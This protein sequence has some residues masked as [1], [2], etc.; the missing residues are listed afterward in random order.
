MT[1]PSSQ[2]S[3]LIN[4]LN[5]AQSNNQQKFDLVFQEQI[6]Q[7]MEQFFDT[8]F[9]ENID[10]L[11]QGVKHPTQLM[12]NRIKQLISPNKQCLPVGIDIPVFIPS[13]TEPKATVVLLGQ[14]PLRKYKDIDET[15][16]PDYAFIG[17]PYSI[18]HTAGLPSATRVYPKLIDCLLAD[19]YNVYLTD[20]KKY[21]PSSKKITQENMDL[22]VEELNCLEGKRILIL[23]GRRA[24]DNKNQLS[25]VHDIPLPHLSGFGASSEWKK[26]AKSATHP[27]KIEYVMEQI[28][29][30]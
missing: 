7:L 4:C 24:K 25:G 3:A 15:K 22:L 16:V 27:A 28:N 26:L 6:I 21:Y 10:G 14:D 29:K 12:N 5:R 18:H 30:I 19:G 1:E 11:M 23:S 13:K 8:S 9:K 20:V 17:T 2:S